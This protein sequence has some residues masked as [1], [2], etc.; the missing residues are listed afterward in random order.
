MHHE[1]NLRYAGWI[2]GDG[3]PHRSVG[4]VFDWFALEFWTKDRL[5]MSSE[6]WAS[7][8]PVNDYN[9]GVVA[10]GT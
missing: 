10:K 6:Q 9:Y 1:W 4:E 7:A 3:E 8:I 5:G 2:I